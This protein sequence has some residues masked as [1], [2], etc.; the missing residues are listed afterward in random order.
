MGPDPDRGLLVL[1][2]EIDLP[3]P[4]CGGR[5]S[6]CGRPGLHN[7]ITIMNITLQ[8]EMEDAGMWMCC[9]REN[10][11]K[12]VQMPAVRDSAYFSVEQVTAPFLKLVG[13]MA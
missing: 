1:S 13:Y 12:R 7:L 3:A 8:C 5:A 11:E 4:A 9:S 2:C 6:T 10:R